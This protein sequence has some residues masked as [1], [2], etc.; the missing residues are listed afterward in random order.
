M[1]ERTVPVRRNRIGGDENFAARIP[2]RPR[3]AWRARVRQRCGLGLGVARPHPQGATG[4]R[5]GS[6]RAEARGEF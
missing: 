6:P 4:G 2:V 3:F 1:D 5:H